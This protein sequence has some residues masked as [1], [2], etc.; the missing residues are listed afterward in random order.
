[1]GYKKIFRKDVD[2]KNTKLQSNVTFNGFHKCH[3]IY[4]SH[5]FADNGIL[6]DKP[7]YLG[8]ALLELK[9]LLK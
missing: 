9:E 2:E 7:I 1:M 6:R 3:T 8:L 5:S 4:D